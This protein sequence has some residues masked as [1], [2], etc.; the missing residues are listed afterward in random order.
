MLR[1][2]SRPPLV[3]HTGQQLKERSEEVR[4][5][6]GDFKRQNATTTDTTVH[7]TSF[8]C[9]QKIITSQSVFIYCSSGFLPLNSAGCCGTIVPASAEKRLAGGTPF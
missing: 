1:F 6:E 2:Q 3:S 7:V 8:Y 9:K 4:F 5:N